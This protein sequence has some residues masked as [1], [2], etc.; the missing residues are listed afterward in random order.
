MLEQTG[1]S[2][3]AAWK[4]I[5]SVTTVVDET[6]C[7]A[8]AKEHKLKLASGWRGIAQRACLMNL[9]GTPDDRIDAIM[10]QL[11][12]TNH[13][14]E[15]SEAQARHDHNWLVNNGFLPKDTALQMRVRGQRRVDKDEVFRLLDF[16]L[17][18]A[19]I[20]GPRGQVKGQTETMALRVLGN[21]C[22]IGDD[23]RSGKLK[24]LNPFMSRKAWELLGKMALKDWVENTESDHWETL[25]HLW[26]WMVKDSPNRDDLLARIEK[27]PIVTLTKRE[28]AELDKAP[29][30]YYGPIE[31]YGDRVEVVKRVKLE[32]D[33]VEVVRVED[34]IASAF[35]LR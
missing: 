18:E 30:K 6:R 15:K 1:P 20:K 32:C 26:A 31:R 10:A 3:H 4:E 17:H 23:A 34:D 33:S 27:W 22:A 35:R 29:W 21:W 11:E 24:A 7:R 2:K 12:W 8:L 19:R 13:Y 25:D 14:K 5:V 28:H 9:D 16:A